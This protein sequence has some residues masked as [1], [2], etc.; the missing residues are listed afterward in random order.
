MSRAQ[1]DLTGR[2]QTHRG[3]L[4]SRSLRIVGRH[5]V[6]ELVGMVQWKLCRKPRGALQQPECNRHVGTKA[7]QPPVLT[8][9]YCCGFKV[10]VIPIA[11][12]SALI[13]AAQIS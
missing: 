6:T 11:G 5:E 4:L 13:L 2:R 1:G 7:W 10:D 9:R 12:S 3:P 8:E